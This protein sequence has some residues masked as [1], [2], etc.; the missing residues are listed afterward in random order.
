MYLHKLKKPN[1]D[2][3]LS[4]KEKYHVP[5]KGAREKTVKSLGYVSELQKTYED[6][7]V[8]FSQMAAEMTAQK[9]KE[10]SVR[11]FIDTTAKMSTDVDDVKNVGYGVLKELYKQL[12]E[13]IFY[14]EK[15]DELLI[16]DTASGKEQRKP[17]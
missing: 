6:P 5:G 8:Y 17:L 12:D 9:K 4:I 11:I 14:L 3:Y 13:V 1:G 10:Q 15:E 2:I 16:F 7:I